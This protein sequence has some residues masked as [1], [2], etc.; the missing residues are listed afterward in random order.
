MTTSKDNLE[1]GAG[2]P[3]V[4]NSGPPDPVTRGTT[5]TGARSATTALEHPDLPTTVVLSVVLAPRSDNTPNDMEGCELSAIKTVG[6]LGTG[7]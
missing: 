3:L 7:P 4:E 6:S 2:A 5:D 1:L